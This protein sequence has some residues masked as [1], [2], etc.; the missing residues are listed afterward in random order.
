MVFCYLFVEGEVFS[1][2]IFFDWNCLLIVLGEW[3]LDYSF[4]YYL[5]VVFGIEIEWLCVESECYLCLGLELFD[6]LL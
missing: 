3:L 6:D 2:G 5:M 4:L 1:I